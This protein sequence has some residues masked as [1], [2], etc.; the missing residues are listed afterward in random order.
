VKP[1]PESGIDH[2]LPHCEADDIA[3]TLPEPS[4][5]G[6]SRFTAGSHMSTSRDPDSLEAAAPTGF[7]DEDLDLQAVL[8]ASLMSGG[9]TSFSLP[10]TRVEAPPPHAIARPPVQQN[11]ML[12][13]LLGITGI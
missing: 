13:I 1:L 4:S 3:S 11:G 12:L 9:P 8:Q 2:S 7:E 5:S 6:L 10:L